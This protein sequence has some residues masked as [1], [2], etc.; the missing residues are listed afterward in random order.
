MCRLLKED[1][2]IIL[3]FEGLHAVL[4]HAHKS[5]L[6]ALYL[7]ACFL[8]RALLRNACMKILRAEPQNLDVFCIEHASVNKKV[9]EVDILLSSHGC[10][11]R[12]A[13]FIAFL[14]RGSENQKLDSEKLADVSQQMVT[15]TTLICL[16]REGP[17]GIPG[18]SS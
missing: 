16:Q 2:I 10:N 15:R 3:S 6:L 13:S 12:E 14:A 17:P 1:L 4:I 9:A 7:S 5:C 8:G 18:R 11:Q